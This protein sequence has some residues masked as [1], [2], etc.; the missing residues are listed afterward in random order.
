MWVAMV[1][2]MQKGSFIQITNNVYTGKDSFTS[3]VNAGAASLRR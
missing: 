2:P 3:V 1:D